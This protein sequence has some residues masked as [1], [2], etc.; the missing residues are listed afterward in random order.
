M[1]RPSVNR[2][3]GVSQHLQYILGDSLQRADIVEKLK[4]IKA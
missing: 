1:D 4:V 3:K 2:G